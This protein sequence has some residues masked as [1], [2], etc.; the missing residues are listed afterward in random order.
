MRPSDIA[1]K[2][3]KETTSGRFSASRRWSRPTRRSSSACASRNGGEKEVPPPPQAPRRRPPQK[4]AFPPHP[5]PGSRRGVPR[6]R[7][8]LPPKTPPR[9]AD[10]ARGLLGSPCPWGPRGRSHGKPGAH[11]PSSPPI[12][13]GEY[14]RLT[15]STRRNASYGTTPFTL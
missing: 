4:E 1:P 7:G 3:Q 6:P 14:S 9:G 15:T 8:A 12:E 11:I 13:Q 2:C 5:P 10:P